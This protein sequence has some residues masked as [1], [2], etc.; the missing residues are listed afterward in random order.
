MLA[1]SLVNNSLR[2][3]INYEGSR[4]YF[5]VISLSSQRDTS[6]V[7]ATTPSTVFLLYTQ[8]LTELLP[9]INVNFYQFF[10]KELMTTLTSLTV[11]DKLEQFNYVLLGTF[12]HLTCFI[13]TVTF[14]LLRVNREHSFRN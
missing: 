7:G 6:G 1:T 2:T 10:F 4:Q 5:E 11:I 9:K 12:E 13:F 8:W 14:N 3:P